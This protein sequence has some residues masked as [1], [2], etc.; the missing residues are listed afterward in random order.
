[1]SEKL[2][3]PIQRE[4]NYLRINRVLFDY[5]AKKAVLEFNLGSKDNEDY[6]IPGERVTITKRFDDFEPF[7]DK[8]LAIS[9]ADF[10][11][12]IRAIGVEK[13]NKL[14]NKNKSESIIGG[15]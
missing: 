6:F 8:I 9:K 13:V 15:K 14:Y 3:N 11:K 4:L 7:L 10:I 12:N 5:E 1:M 2:S